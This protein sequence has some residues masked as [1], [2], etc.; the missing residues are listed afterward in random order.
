[1]SFI[2]ISNKKPE[3]DESEEPLLLEIV[4]PKVIEKKD[5]LD[6]SGEMKE[7]AEEPEKKD[8]DQD[9]EAEKPKFKPEGFSWTYYDG[10]P[11]NYVQVISKFT[12]YPIIE[13]HSTVRNMENTIIQ[14][15]SSDIKQ[16]DGKIHL[17]SY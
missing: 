4:K 14:I 9:G 12:K 17:I 3:I 6:I 13:D 7:N 5:E 10:K 11:R 2:N 8:E 1:M 16:K 15:L